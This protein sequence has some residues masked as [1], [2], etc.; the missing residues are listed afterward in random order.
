MWPRPC[1]AAPWPALVEHDG[2][3]AFGFGDD[4]IL[5]VPG[6]K[7]AGRPDASAF[8][9]RPH[10]AL[11]VVAVTGTNGKTSTAWWLAQL[12]SAA[13]ALRGGR[14][15]GHWPPPVGTGVG[16]D[17]CVSS[18]GLTTPDPVMLQRA[19]GSWRSRA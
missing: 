11:D 17:R 12:L 14:H 4:R 3:E 6:L 2:V 5:A 13:A 7:A 19:C 8:Q 1:S 10:A 15:A 16:V 9:W 18:T